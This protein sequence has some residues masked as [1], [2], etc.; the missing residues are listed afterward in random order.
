MDLY[1]GFTQPHDSP[2]MTE[3]VDTV[4]TIQNTVELQTN[5]KE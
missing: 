3:M 4:E 5:I 1:G 2:D